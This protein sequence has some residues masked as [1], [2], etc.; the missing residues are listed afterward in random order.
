MAFHVG[1]DLVERAADGSEARLGERLGHRARHALEGTALG[2]GI[3]AKRHAERIPAVEQRVFRDEPA[4]YIRQALVE[5]LQVV[6][7]EQLRAW[8]VSIPPLQGEVGELIQQEPSS[9]GYTAILEYQ[10]PM[11]A[12]R[13]DV[14]LLMRGAVLV[15]ELK[16]KSVVDLADVDQA[17]AY[18]RDLRA[19]HRECAERAVF[20]ALV[21]M[22]RS[23]HVTETAGVEVKSFK[24]NEELQHDFYAEVPISIV[25]EGGY[26]DVARFFDLMSKLPRIVNMGSMTMKV[27]SETADQTRIRVSGTATTFRFVG[28]KAEKPEKKA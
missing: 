8:D 26:H 22:N 20:P 23:G 21:L 7:P 3:A 5:F 24:R 14:I 25:I 10:L 28:D 17:S 12:R 11:E 1:D 18:A 2:F 15:L 9:A 19:Y 27:A 4:P 6:S 16:G 13:P